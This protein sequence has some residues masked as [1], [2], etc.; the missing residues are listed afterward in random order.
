MISN[1]SPVAAFKLEDQK[2]VLTGYAAP[3]GESPCLLK[4]VG[5]DTPIFFARAS[6]YS[7]SAAADGF[8]SGCQRYGASG[9]RRQR[10]SPGRNHRAAPND[11][12]VSAGGLVGHGPVVGGPPSRHQSVDG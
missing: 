1:Y 2:D 5:G 7:A 10:G 12:R 6:G 3:G 9:L 8:R 4:L 11:L